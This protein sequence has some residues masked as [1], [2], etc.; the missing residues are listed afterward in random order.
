MKW[1]VLKDKFTALLEKQRHCEFNKTKMTSLMGQTLLLLNLD[2]PAFGSNLVHSP[3]LTHSCT[4]SK[5]THDNELCAPVNDDSK[6][7]STGKFQD[8]NEISI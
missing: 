5:T 1:A 8:W 3:A 6:I 7:D 2:R 4:N